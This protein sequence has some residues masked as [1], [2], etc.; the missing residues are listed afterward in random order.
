MPVLTDELRAAVDAVCAAD[1]QVLSDG[2]SIKALHRQLARLEAATTRAAAAFDARRVWEADGAR[3]AGSWIAVSC[4]L[5][6]ATAQR[7]VHLGRALRHMAMAEQA[8][9]AGDIDGAH[10]SVLARSRTDATA[11]LFARH[12]ELLVGH[13]R[14]LRFGSFARVMA[15]WRYRADPQEAEANAEEQVAARGLHLSRTFSTCTCSTG[16]STR[17]TGPSSPASS[18]AWRRSSSRPTGPRPGPGWARG[19]RLRTWGAARPSAGPTP[20]WR[21]PG[22]REPC[23]PALVCPSPCSVSSSTSRPWP[24]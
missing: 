4:H 2:E 24:G 11:E 3:S 23:R 13:A 19:S 22:A 20:W 21:W 17:S 6:K 9:L 14:D 8:R 18:S 5:P 7:R 10:V 1:P 15:Y 12:E 16:S